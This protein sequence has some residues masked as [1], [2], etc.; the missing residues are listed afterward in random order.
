LEKQGAGYFSLSKSKLKF[1]LEPMLSLDNEGVVGTET[2]FVTLYAP[3]P[4][5]L[6][7]FWLPCIK[8]SV[9]T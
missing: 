2:L 1:V 6:E 7:R 9:L 3:P 5:A 8:V 4:L